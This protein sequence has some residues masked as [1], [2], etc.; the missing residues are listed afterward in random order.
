LDFDGKA[1]RKETTRKT[2]T[3]CLDN[4]K[5]DLR[6]IGWGGIYWIDQTYDRDQWKALVNT[7]LNPQVP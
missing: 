1:R 6:E 7:V 4:I 5:M 3:R 2:K